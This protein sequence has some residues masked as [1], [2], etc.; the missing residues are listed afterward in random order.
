MRSPGLTA[1]R[2]ATTAIAA[3]AS[4]PRLVEL[5]TADITTLPLRKHIVAGRPPVIGVAAPA[6][7]CS[8]CHYKII[9]AARTTVTHQSAGHAGSAPRQVSAIPLSASQRSRS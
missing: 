8:Y 2:L 9:D 3:I 7:T 1:H 4:H 5:M 6:R